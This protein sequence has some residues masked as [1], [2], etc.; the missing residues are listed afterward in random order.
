MG[1]DSVEFVFAIEDAFGVAIADQDAEQMATPRHVVEYLLARLPSTEASIC[2]EQRAFYRLRR[3]IVQAYR[4]PKDS[5]RPDTPWDAI[6][7]KEYA[8]RA[9]DQLHKVV[10]VANWPRYQVFWKRS[11]AATTV[12]ATAHFLASASPAALKVPGE[13]WSRPEV[14]RIVQHLMWEEL[15]INA[16]DWDDQFHKDLGVN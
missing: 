8:A 7:P 3:A 11:Q 4:L 2:S 16:F 15:G 10:G 14:E 6:L 9:W 13:G 12:G 1:L 5:V